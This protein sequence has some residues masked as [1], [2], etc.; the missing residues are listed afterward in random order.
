MLHCCLKLCSH[1]CTKVSFISR[2]ENSGDEIG[3]TFGYAWDAEELPVTSHEIVKCLF[4]NLP[5]SFQSL[6]YYFLCFFFEGSICLMI[7]CGIVDAYD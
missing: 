3:F 2:L 7:G 4:T 5:Y 6:Y 1:F